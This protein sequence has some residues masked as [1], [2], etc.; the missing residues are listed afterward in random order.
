LSLKQHEGKDYGWRSPAVPGGRAQYGQLAH[1]AAYVPFPRPA[2]FYDCPRQP[3]PLLAVALIF[4][5]RA[6][7]VHLDRALIREL[8]VVVLVLVP[9]GS[10]RSQADNVCHY[11]LHDGVWLH[12]YIWPLSWAKQLTDVA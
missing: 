11:R 4:L 9:A 3:R 1:L 10:S 7:V 6:V 5:L 12:W 8:A 2:L